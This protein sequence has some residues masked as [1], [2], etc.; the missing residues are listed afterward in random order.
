MCLN[1]STCW[2]SSI[3]SLTHARARLRYLQFHFLIGRGAQETHGPVGQ[4][5]WKTGTR[6]GALRLFATGFWLF[7]RF[8]S[9]VIAGMSVE[10]CTVYQFQGRTTYISSVATTPTDLEEKI[11][12][13]IVLYVVIYMCIRDFSE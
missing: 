3:S 11:Y 10:T 7:V 12:L 5:S 8:D 4:L 6:C 9:W 13:F 2:S 1:V